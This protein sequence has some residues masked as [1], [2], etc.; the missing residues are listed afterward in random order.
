MQEQRRRSF[1][2]EQQGALQLGLAGMG[3]GGG[4]DSMTEKFSTMRFERGMQPQNLSIQG[5]PEPISPRSPREHDGGLP[6]P[7]SPRGKYTY[8]VDERNR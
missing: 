5:V 3:A 7:D 6:G 4:F 1:E 2:R 8:G